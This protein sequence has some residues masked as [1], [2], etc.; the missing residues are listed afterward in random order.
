M[1]TSAS[2]PPFIHRVICGRKLEALRTRAGFTQGEVANQ[3]GF[4]QGKVVSIEAGTHRLKPKDLDKLLDLFEADEVSREDCAQLAELGGKHPKRNILRSRFEGDVRT[5]IDLESTA[6]TF[7]QHNSMLIPGLLQTEAYMRYVFRAGRP[8][9]TKDQI[10]LFTENRLARQHALDNLDQQFW[11]LVDE[12]ALRR[13]NNMDGG[14]AII[15]EQVEHLMAAID[16][17]NIEVQVVPFS[18]GYYLGQEEDYTIFGYR[19]DPAVQVAYIETY[20]DGDLIQD[21]ERVQRF[22]TLW[23]HQRAAALGPELSRAFL[24]DIASSA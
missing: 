19:A 18:H 9:P 13:M 20:D 7:W 4:S 12:A 22:L 11:F 3:T 17:P 10:D 6:H 21:R 15:R 24:R 14:S 2:L 5:F 16:R 1:S 23:D 8:S